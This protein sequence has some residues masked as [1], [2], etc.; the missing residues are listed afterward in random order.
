VIKLVSI[1]TLT[2]ATCKHSLARKSKESSAIICDFCQ[3]IFWFSPEEDPWK[4]NAGI[5]K[6]LLSVIG[7]GSNLQIKKQSYEVIGLI[8][9]HLTNDVKLFWNLLDSEGNISWLLECHGLFYY[10]KNAKNHARQIPPFE[11]IHVGRKLPGEYFKKEYLVVSKEVSKRYE[12]FGEVYFPFSTDPQLLN[13]EAYDPE[14][15]LAYMFY[16]GKKIRLTW[17]G[18]SI[19]LLKCN[20]SPKRIEIIE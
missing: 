19:D 12:V 16:Y 15:N 14:G 13:C 9:W 10:F 20:V 18:E 5:K 3:T 4:K 17:E 11:V 8:E 7:I 6:E 1:P 2:C